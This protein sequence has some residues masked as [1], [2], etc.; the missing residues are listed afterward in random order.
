MNVAQLSHKV[1]CEYDII[2]LTIFHLVRYILYNLLCVHIIFVFL[3]REVKNCDY[4]KNKKILFLDTNLSLNMIFLF[5]VFIG[6]AIDLKYMNTI[7]EC[8]KR[9]MY[10]INF[11]KIYHEL[12]TFSLEKQALIC[13]NHRAIVKQYVNCDISYL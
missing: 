2:I 12:Y 5:R 3:S 4:L 13:T 7:L 8:M 10:F 11:S 6:R 1:S 9:D